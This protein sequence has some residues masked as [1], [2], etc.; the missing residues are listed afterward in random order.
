[1]EG[2]KVEFSS[3]IKELFEAILLFQKN[4]GKV[5]KTEDN[6][7]FKAKYADLTDVQEVAQPKL[8]EVGLVLSVIPCG[9]N[10]LHGMLVHAKSGQYLSSTF[11]LN[12]EKSYDKEKDKEGK[13]LWR[14]EPYEENQKWGAAVTYGR[15]FFTV[16]VLDLIVDKDNDGAKPGEKTDRSEEEKKPFLNKTKLGS[17]EVLPEY[18]AA[19]EEAKREGNLNTLKA[20]FRMTTAT[21]QA[22]ATDADI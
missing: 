1:M 9:D 14:S 17:T 11:K 21:Q 2:Y 3:E 22:L 18:L 12:I 6:P 5:Y 4:V 20:R 15:R 16:A 7:F 8:N 13:I 10:Y 19:V